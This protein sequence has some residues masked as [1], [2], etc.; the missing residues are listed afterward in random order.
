ML[1]RWIVGR[2]LDEI[3]H[4]RGSNTGQGTQ[5]RNDHLG[6][7]QTPG[8]Y[9]KVVVRACMKNF[10]QHLLSYTPTMN[11]SK[12]NLG[13]LRCSC[14]RAPEQSVNTSWIHGIL[15]SI[16][17]PLWYPKLSPLGSPVP[18][19]NRCVKLIDRIKN[20]NK[21]KKNQRVQI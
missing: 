1:G 6:K 2:Y 3:E 15:K 16:V 9:P 4:V 13:R 20:T 8:M 12:R 17:H 14:Q 7:Y 11:G 21:L 10:A 19:Y 5:K 18:D